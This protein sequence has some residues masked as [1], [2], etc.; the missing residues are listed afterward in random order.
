[1]DGTAVI[2]DQDA[3]AGGA[4]ASIAPAPP[5]AKTLALPTSIRFPAD[6]R[7]RCS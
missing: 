5:M 7:L 1:M 3:K 6:M 2:V 4:G